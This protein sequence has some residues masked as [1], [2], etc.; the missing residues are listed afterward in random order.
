VPHHGIG[1]AIVRRVAHQHGGELLQLERPGGGAIARL[2][3][4]VGNADTGAAAAATP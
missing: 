2:Q 4:P 3:L 1:L